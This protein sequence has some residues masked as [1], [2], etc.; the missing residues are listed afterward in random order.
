[1]RARDVMTTRV[2]TVGEDTPVEEIA[3]KLLEHRISAVPVVDAGGML[4][5][6]VS[7][8]DLMRRAHSEAARPASWWLRLV[9]LPHEAD[10]YL[11]AH[12]RVASDVM[13]RKLFTVDEGTPLVEIVDLLERKR[14][15][16]VPVVR[17]GKVVGIVSRANLLHGL[18]TSRTVV[19]PSSDNDRT[20][21]DKLFTAMT[22][23]ADIDPLFLNVTVYDGV[24][25]LWGLV[26]SEAE[27]RAARLVAESTPGIR[28]VDDHLGVMPPHLG[29][30]MWT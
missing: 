1:M 22:E 20:L 26:D 6:I 24:A 14:I 7:E 5:G 28:A 29:S 23:Q 30:M 3:R 12:G 19:S 17:H 2:V 11:Q 27:K 9:A 21:R 15:K 10:L 13:T 25:H 18:A 16:R 4:V 8:G